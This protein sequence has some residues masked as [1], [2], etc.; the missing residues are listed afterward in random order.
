MNRIRFYSKWTGFL[1]Q[2]DEAY[3]K[4]DGLTHDG[5]ERSLSRAGRTTGLWRRQRRPLGQC[6]PITIG[7]RH[8]DVSVRPAIQFHSFLSAGEFFQ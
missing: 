3:L 6:E 5:L 4:E 7:D 2:D 8:G 1:W